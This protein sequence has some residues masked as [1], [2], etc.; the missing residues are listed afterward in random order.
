MIGGVDLLRHLTYFAAVAEHRHF[1]DA[2]ISLGITQPPLSQGIQRLERQWGVRLFER[3]ARTVQIT[4]VGA[5]LLSGTHEI[6]QQVD[7]LTDLATI[8][9]SPRRVRLGLASDL[10]AAIVQLVHTLVKEDLQ[11]DPTIGG[12]VDLI[13]RLKD[14]E[15]DAVQICHPAVVDGVWAGPV[16]V[17]PTR[18]IGSAPGTEPIV[19]S[20]LA[21]PFVV[22]PRRDHPPLHDQFID[23]LRRHGHDG[24][25][26]EAATPL[27]RDAI[28]AAGGGV[29]LTLDPN[30]GRPILDQPLPMRIRTVLPV[31]S[32]R[33][34]EIDYAAVLKAIDE[35]LPR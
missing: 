33:R 4:D 15:L 9:T 14:G 26:I 35:A 20:A 31:E 6:L 22:A 7:D 34:P 32:H 19:L 11:I 21:L 18:L 27:E 10:D 17:L 13:E 28:V 16:T 8:W 3:N 2:A 12:T 25:V 29:R 1:G 23:A 5:A 30:L 24:S